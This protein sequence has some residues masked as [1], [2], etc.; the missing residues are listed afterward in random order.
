MLE[1]VVDQFADHAIENHL[2]VGVVTFRTEVRRETDL[3]VV[4][5]SAL[6]DEVLHAPRQPEVIEHVGRKVVRNLAQRTDRLVDHIGRIVYDLALLGVVLLTREGRKRHFGRR[7]Q[8]PETVVQLLRETRPGLLLGAEHGREDTLVEQRPLTVQTV[9]VFEQLVGVH[10]ADRQADRDHDPQITE[11]PAGN[12]LEARYE[13]QLD[14]AFDRQQRKAHDEKNPHRIV[15][16]GAHQP[17]GI[18]RGDALD[19]DG[20]D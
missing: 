11:P 19:D 5:R 8:R 16:G 6:V 12:D 4:H 2:D 1:R 17:Q 7:E 14:E 3:H 9:D 20:Y 18:A 13:K 10:H 15:F